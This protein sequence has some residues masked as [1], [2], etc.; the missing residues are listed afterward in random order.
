M[1]RRTLGQ[2]YLTDASVVHRLVS[3]AGLHGTEDV[4]EIGTGKGVLTKELAS[5]CKRLEG[6]EVDRRNYEETKAVATAR[7]VFIRLEDAFDMKPTFD[8]VVSSLPYSRSQDFVEWIS[9]LGYDRGVVV[10]QKDFVDKIR[11]PPGTRDYRAVSVI[12]QMSLEMKEMGP[13]NRSAFHPPPKVSSVILAIRPRMR[14]KEEEI[15]KIKMLFSLRRR[16]VSNVLER[17]GFAAR[18]DDF[19]DRRI[20]SLTPEEVHQI[21]DN[22]DENRGAQETEA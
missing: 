16:R 20:S 2:H 19:G 4:V 15:A 9:Q 3:A 1:K 6:F 14:L 13:V 17:F 5:R 21:C 12:A 11:S 18:P 22:L 10:L 7:N 8:V